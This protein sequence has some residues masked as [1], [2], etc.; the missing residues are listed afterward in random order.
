M[1][2]PM[3]ERTQTID[4]LSGFPG[5]VLF[6]TVNQSF[7]ALTNHPVITTTRNS[8]Y[9]PIG[10]IV[11]PALPEENPHRIML[12]GLCQLVL[13]AG[14]GLWIGFGIDALSHLIPIA[15]VAGL[16]D[17]WSVSSGATSVI[18]RSSQIHYF[19]LRFP[20]LGGPTPEM[21]FLIGLTDFLFFG[22]F[23]T[24]AFRFGLGAVRN[25]IL[26]GLSFPITVTLAIFFHVGLP[27]LPIMALLFV[28]GNYSRLQVRKDE[29]VKVGIFLVLCGAVALAVSS[30]LHR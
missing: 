19:L 3:V 20:L 1:A 27:V 26:L 12:L 21:P 6:L 30:W 7:P 8:F 22:I 4:L 25:L 9:Q 15:L 13:A 18:I 10:E 17:I 28:G 29:L 16:A 5:E 23:F 11:E 14:L 24:A 2:K